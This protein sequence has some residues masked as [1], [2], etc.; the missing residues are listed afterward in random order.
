M[1]SV[2]R[3]EGSCLANFYSC[4]ATQGSGSSDPKNGDAGAG[5]RESMIIHAFSY[6]TV[7]N[8]IGLKLWSYSVCFV[9]WVWV[10]DVQVNCWGEHVLRPLVFLDGRNDSQRRAPNVQPFAIRNPARSTV[11]TG[12]TEAVMWVAMFFCYGNPVV[13]WHDMYECTW[14]YP[15]NNK[16]IIYFLVVSKMLNSKCI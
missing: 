3:E 1:F 4:L 11:T 2:F 14:R 5:P 7:G 9:W 15:M 6:V 12:L 13:W 16:W 10:Q 8:R